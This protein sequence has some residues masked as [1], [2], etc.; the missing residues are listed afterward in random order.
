[1]SEATTFTGTDDDGEDFTVVCH[2]GCPGGAQGQHKM[3]CVWSGPW[4][5]DGYRV[6]ILGHSSGHTSA[7][8]CTEDE[9]GEHAH[10]DSGQLT[11]VRYGDIRVM[12]TRS[13]G[14]TMA[15]MSKVGAAL[16]KAGHGDRIEDLTEE[17]FAAQSYDHALQIL[18]EWVVCY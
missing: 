15:L 5:V 4:F 9:R 17:V 2:N 16:R 14:N 7:Q 11:R 6:K 12:L 13:D 1:M 3:S 10:V 18:Q 8:V